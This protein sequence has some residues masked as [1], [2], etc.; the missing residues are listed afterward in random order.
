MS[1]NS[2]NLTNNPEK[3][4]LPVFGISAG[5]LA[6][7]VIGSLINI[8]FVTRIV[9]VAQEFSTRYFG[10]VWQLLLLATFIMAL[11]LA[12]SRYGS[13]RVGGLD[14]PEISTFRWI[15]MIMC[16]LLAAGGVFWSSAEPIYHFT[17]IPPAFTGVEA[18]TPGAVSPAL[19][20]CYLH[21][22]FLAWAILGTLG[23]V[24]LMYACYH[25]GMPIKPRALLYP[26]LGEKGVNSHLGT[27]VDTFSIIAVAAGT[28]GPIGFLGLQLSYALEYLLGIPDVYSSQLAV[29]AVITVIYTI[30]AS[31]PIYKGINGLSK[32]NVLIAIGLMAAITLLGP[33]AFIVD[34]F[35]SAFGLYVQDFFRMSL[36]RS[37]PDWMGWWTVFYWG[38]FLGYGPM[39][40]I[41][42][43]RISRGR[44]IREIMLAVAVIA[45]VVTNIWFSVLGGAGIHFELINP[46]SVSTALTESGLPAALLAIVEQLPLSALLIPVALL[47][48]GLFLI[49]TGAGMTYSIAMSV[50]GKENPPKWVRILWGV[51]MGAMAAVLIN[52]GD[53]G[54]KALQTFIIVSAVPVTLFYIPQLWMSMGC[55]RLMYEE[56]QEKIAGEGRKISL[57]DVA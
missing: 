2:S 16:A 5:F 28:I 36:D 15:S 57:Q 51:L 20:Q 55:A 24:I 13:V 41:F 6:L 37:N 26:L 7:F 49:T 43:T 52:I 39:M 54:I 40:A 11:V 4:N 14:K 25:K 32:L 12:I 46:G 42:T 45:P 35:M 21:W 48:V 19:A 22:G 29:I 10:A 44:T 18:S 1:E 38:W 56:Q 33:G 9:N 31:T 30:A 27:A 17:S 34:S 53:G 47:L 50:T 8:E 3:T 23:T